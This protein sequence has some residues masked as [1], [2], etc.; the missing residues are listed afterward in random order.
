LLNNEAPEVNGA[1]AHRGE[2]MSREQRLGAAMLAHEHMDHNSGGTHLKG[3]AASEMDYATHSFECQGCS[4]LCEV[5][6][7]R[8]G[9]EVLARWGGRCGKWEM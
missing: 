9:R 4:N 1:L 3:F 5:V 8:V 7:I 2:G 6:E